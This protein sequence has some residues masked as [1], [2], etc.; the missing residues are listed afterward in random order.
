[1]NGWKR[2]QT[3]FTASADANLR[4]MFLFFDAQKLF[5]WN[6]GLLVLLPALVYLV[7]RNL[8]YTL[9]AA[10]VVAI[11]PRLTYRYLAQHRLRSFQNSL[12]DALAQLAGAM[13]AGSA[14][15]NAIDVMVKETQGPV[16]QEFSLV[17]REH[18]VGVPMEE[19]FTN[20]GSR[21]QCEDLELVIAAA[22]IAREVGGNL[23][24][25]F[26]RLSTTLREKATMEGKIRALTAQ[27]K[28]Q[29]WVVGLLPVAMMI[30]LFHLEP[31]VMEPWSSTLLGWIYT[32]VIA[33]LE[34]L[35][36]L[37]IRKIVSI[38]V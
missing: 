30:I 12:P 16:S 21:V 32:T 9:L 15:P 10:T 11:L 29:G 26:D 5:L 7:T 19:A 14:L 3:R 20:L 23:A 4:Q 2:Y 28:L 22:L 36:L 24:E 27:G 18:R 6:I 35:G 25:V 1:M 37:M 8:T 34:L 13:R 38:D 17:L 33:V 31:D